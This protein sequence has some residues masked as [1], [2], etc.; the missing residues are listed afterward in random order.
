MRRRIFWI[1]VLLSLI[2]GT[3]NLRASPVLAETD[4]N[5]TFTDYLPA[6]TIVYASLRTSD[7]QASVDTLLNL[8]TTIGGAKPPDP[9]QQ[10]DQSLTQFLGRP[11]TFA[12]DILPWLGDH[13]SV[14]FVLSEA[15]Q[16]N[17]LALPNAM[18][19][20]VLLAA[21]KDQAAGDT[22]A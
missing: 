12:K 16:G 17:L 6:D 18:N 19:K 15:E 20:L 22:F 14:G 4:D 7:I 3:L 10:L 11:A 13:V 8:A 1:I 2:A 5:A 9:Y 21:V